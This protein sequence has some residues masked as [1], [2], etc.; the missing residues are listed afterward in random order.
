[1]NAAPGIERMS[2]KELTKCK[3]YWKSGQKYCRC[4]SGKSLLK[5]KG[6][7]KEENETKKLFPFI[8]N[9]TDRCSN[10][11]FYNLNGACV[12]Q[13]GF[14]GNACECKKIS[15]SEILTFAKSI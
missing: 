10:H 11:G 9:K 15:P 3:C 6:N 8:P 5:Q 2:E 7:R 12:C 1:M 14:H 13:E 4:K